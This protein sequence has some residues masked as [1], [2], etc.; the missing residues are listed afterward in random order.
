M[1]YPNISVLQN[2]HCMAAPA[3][4]DL[5]SISPHH[6]NGSPAQGFSPWFLSI[7]YVLCTPD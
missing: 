6:Q 2:L 4:L 3:L 1:T 7:H 5:K